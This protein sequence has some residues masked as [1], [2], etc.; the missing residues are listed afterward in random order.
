[1]GSKTPNCA[2]E[3]HEN[4]AQGRPEPNASRAQQSFGK[5]CLGAAPHRPVPGSFLPGLSWEEPESARVRLWAASADQEEAGKGRLVPNS[6]PEN[7][8]PP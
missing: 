2:E 6:R 8:K 3:K 5:V 4:G 7:Y 1:M